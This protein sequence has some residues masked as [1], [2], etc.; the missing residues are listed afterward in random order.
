M[1]A[2]HSMMTVHI[3]ELLGEL[4]HSGRHVLKAVDGGELMESFVFNLDR[5]KP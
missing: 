1:L 2:K 4:A 5:H 3:P